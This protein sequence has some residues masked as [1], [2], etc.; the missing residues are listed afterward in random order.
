MNTLQAI[1]EN[2]LKGEADQVKQLVAQA[3]TEG[4]PAAQILNDSLIRGM[5]AIG[6]QFKRGEAFLPEV[7]FAARAMK[8]GMEILEPILAGQGTEP[9][10]RVVI[11]TVKGD[12]HDIGKNLVGVMLK[13]GG[14]EVIDLGVDTAPERFVQAAKEHNPQIVGM[15]VVLG[16]CLGAV[17]DTIAALANSG[18]AVKTLIGG[19][20]VTQGFANEVGAHGYAPDAATAV[21]K[22]KELVGK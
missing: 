4:K 16:T 3:L 1:Y 12:I 9:A 19:P 22:A 5:M 6:E 20:M 8:G 14:F 2:L 7:L 13:G 11:G 18:L 15:S 17:K 10:G 21:D